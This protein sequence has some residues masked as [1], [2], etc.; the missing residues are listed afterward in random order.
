MPIECPIQFNP[1]PDFDFNEID[2]QV[3]ACAYAAQNALGRLCEEQVYE[4][5]I[6]GSLREQ[7][8]REVKTQVP[9]T[10]SIRDFVKVYRL[11]LV[12]SGMVYELKTAERLIPAHDA[13]VFN[14]AALLDLDRIKLLNFGRPTVEG[15][16]RRCP[17]ANMDR[18]RVSI[19]QTRWKPLSKCCK[20]LAIR[21]EECIREWGGFIDH[22]LIEEALVFFQ[23]GAESCVQRLP[24]TR[25]DRHLGTQRILMHAPELAFSVTAMGPENAAYESQLRRL[26]RLLPLRGWQWINIHHTNLRL[27]TLEQQRDFRLGAG[28]MAIS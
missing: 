14:Y 18:R 22:R 8:I 9:I 26:L 2:R 1:L 15:R 12:V 3:M 28:N 24:I 10:V 27:V 11:D 21:A 7:G 5:D 17:F 19:D 23:G 6:A 25:S 20:T 13:Q 4:N 16:L